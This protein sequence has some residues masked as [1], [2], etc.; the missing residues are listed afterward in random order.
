MDEYKDTICDLMRRGLW[1]DDLTGDDYEKAREVYEEVCLDGMP[2]RAITC[3][4]CGG[5]K[6]H[7]S[8]WW[9]EDED[10]Y[11]GDVP[12]ER[13]EGRGVI[14][15]EDETEEES[16]ERAQK[17]RPKATGYHVWNGG[18]YAGQ[19]RFIV[20]EENNSHIT[21]FFAGTRKEARALAEQH[22]QAALSSAAAGT[23]PV[24]PPNATT[25]THS[26]SRAAT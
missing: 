13:C 23:H 10:A 4:E 24:C 6:T 11:Y 12:C 26:P 16:E 18:I 3:P 15:L 8:C 9:G 25:S 7:F 21:Q 5:E 1:D 14:R 17:E 22:V 2:L 19:F 20:T